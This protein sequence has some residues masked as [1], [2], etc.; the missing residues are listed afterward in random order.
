MPEFLP[1]EFRSAHD[2][3]FFLHDRLADIVVSGEKAG[4][5]QVTFELKSPSDADVFRTLP[6]EELWDWLQDNGYERIVVELANRQVMAALLSDLCHFVYEALRCSAKGKLVVA[7]A[8]LRKP[9]KDNL[10]YLEWLLADPDDFQHKFHEESPEALAQTAPKR[11]LAIIGAAIDKT[12]YPG[13]VSARFIYELRYDKRATYGLEGLWNKATH[14]ITTFHPAYTTEAQNFNFVFSDE[15]ARLQQWRVLY[16]LLPL[17]LYHTV[18]IVEALV[19]TIVDRPRLEAD[20]HYIQQVVGFLLF[21]EGFE[22]NDQERMLL[23]PIRDA[24]DRLELRCPTCG[25]RVSFRAENLGALYR[26]GEVR[27]GIC[28]TN[29]QLSQRIGSGESG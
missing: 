19:A 28:D 12:R 21:A 8:L 4:D 5:F 9:F 14:L 1:K 29:I 11:K 25:R 16:L 6:G 22:T 3:A 17:L 27:C 24:L 10:F 15:E 23:S 2:F 26:F 7:Y 20:L 13:W 18:E